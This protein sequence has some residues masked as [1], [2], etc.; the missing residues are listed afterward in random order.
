MHEHAQPVDR[1]R[2]RGSIAVSNGTIASLL[3]RLLDALIVACPESRFDESLGTR[4]QQ[5]RSRSLNLQV[6]I[7]PC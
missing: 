7:P 4:R 5:L 6:S 2:L 3:Q 1:S